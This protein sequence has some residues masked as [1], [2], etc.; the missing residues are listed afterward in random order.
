[1]LLVGAALFVRSLAKLQDIEPGFDPS[2]VLV[3]ELT[4][5][6]DEQ[7]VSREEANLLY[8][9]LVSRAESVPGVQAASASFTSL[10]TS[11]QWGNAITVEGFVSQPGVTPRTFANAISPR[12]FEVMRIAVRGGRA[13]GEADH[14]TAPRVAIVNRTFARQFFGTLDP[15]GR[16]VGL[17]SPAKQMMEVVGLVEDAKYVDLREDRRP[18]LYVPFPQYRQQNL[19]ELEV[20]TA[21][22]PTT[23]AAMLRRELAAVDSRLAIVGTMVLR[24]RVDASI[25]P[26]RLVA[27][28]SAGFGLLAL[29][30]AAVGLYG[31]V[32]Y[33][34]TQRTGE[35]GI[36]MALG[37]DGRSVRRLVLG[38]TLRLVGIGVA[39][40]VPMALGAARL[41]GSQLYGVTPHDPTAVALALA[42][43]A[44]PAI[45]AGYLP[46]RRAAR[47]D[48]LVALRCE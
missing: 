24:D 36:R 14:E 40:G 8:R 45:V 13:F 16:H 1:V 22:A 33:V 31:V 10:F 28:L 9:R 47:V 19:R 46:A 41:L 27:R 2:R 39:I 29:I 26:E 43:L 35:I 42:T 12:Y 44:L 18:M 15:I 25:A 7:P 3:F 17:G 37:A 5:P 6:V 38:D 4:P 23:V 32:A 48:P 21:A 30:L 34:T 20:R 11:G